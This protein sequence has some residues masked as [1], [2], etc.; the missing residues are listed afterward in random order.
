MEVISRSTPR[1]RR[2]CFLHARAFGE[3]ASQWDLL[4]FGRG[5]LGIDGQYDIVR[6]T[7]TDGSNVPRMPPQRVGGGAYW[8]NE[9]WF[10]RTGLIHAFAQ[11]RLAEHETPTAG[12][13]L[14]KAEISYRSLWRSPAWG[15]VEITT[16]VSGNNLLDV[17]IRNHVQFHKDEVLLPGRS[18]K[19]FLN[20]KYGEPG[21]PPASAS[22]SSRDSRRL[23]RGLP[24]GSAYAASA[25]SN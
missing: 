18:F 2:Y 20:A 14:M 8:R 23:G 21:P 9:D 25:H 7:F 11:Y 19:F 24:V 6:A 5:V 1:A 16:G 4:P 17:D 3:L 15:P 12:Y 13:N 22:G 10:V